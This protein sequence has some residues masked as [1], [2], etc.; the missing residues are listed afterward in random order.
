MKTTTKKTANK[1]KV[2]KLTVGP[3]SLELAKEIVPEYV[4][5][6]QYF[7]TVDNQAENYN[8]VTERHWAIFDKIEKQFETI[9]K[10]QLV[11]TKHFDS[12]QFIVAKVSK[13][14]HNSYQAVDGPVVRVADN[15][16]SW[17]VDGCG[18]CWVL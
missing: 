6:S 1:L 7:N 16:G 4:E 11:V 17:R 14:D 3:I 10:G 18:Y 2:A 13:V 15:T 8:Q 12:D 5:F 9:K